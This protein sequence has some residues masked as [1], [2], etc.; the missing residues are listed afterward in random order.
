MPA[1]G[2]LSIRHTTRNFPNREGSK[3]SEGQIATVALMDA[4]SI[5]A[6]S[7]NGGFLTAA[8]DLDFDEFEKK[9]TFDDSS[10]SRV[11]NGFKKEKR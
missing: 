7:L 4:R 11:Y 10:Y 6:T 3:P 1:N 2:S 8:T 5:A 9:Y